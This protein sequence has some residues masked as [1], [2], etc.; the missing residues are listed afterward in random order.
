MK[1]KM[2]E[3]KGHLK[4]SG[5]QEN[6]ILFWVNLNYYLLQQFFYSSYLKS[7]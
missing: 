1:E 3:N 6:E 7:S 2:K 4:Y 5:L